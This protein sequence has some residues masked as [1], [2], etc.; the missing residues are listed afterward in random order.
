MPKLS[1]KGRANGE[2]VVTQ[3]VTDLKTEAKNGDQKVETA[4]QK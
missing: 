4:V 3:N 2:K 1:D